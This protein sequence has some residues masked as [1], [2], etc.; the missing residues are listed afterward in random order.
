MMHSYIRLVRWLVPAIAL[1]A[2][3]ASP[4]I[5]A[6]PAVTA[7]ATI[8]QN[9]P[10]G[11]MTVFAAS[12]NGKLPP[13]SAFHITAAE[14][15]SSE[16]VAAQRDSQSGQLLFIS[17]M[18]DESL[19]G[20]TLE[21]QATPST[22]K[23]VVTIT[24][25]EAGWQFS[26]ADRPMLFF[27]TQVKAKDG[28]YARAAYVHP[29]LG[30]A[31]ETLTED[32]PADHLHHRGVYWAWHQ[33]WVGDRRGGDLWEAKQC[34]TVVKN[35]EIV[36]QGPIFATL[37]ATSQWESPLISDE[38]GKPIP[39][40]EE[41]VVIRVYHAFFD[42]QYIDFE[43][44]LKPLLPDIRIGGS[45]DVK[46]YSGFTVRVKPPA[47]MKITDANG[48]LS[49]DGLHRV[50]TWADVSGGFGKNSGATG[51]S[52]LAHPSLPEFPP[53]WLL[54]HYGM[55]NVLYPGR[56][57]VALSAD[58]PLTLKH[59]LVIHRGDAKQ[60]RVAEHQLLY[61]R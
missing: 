50:S 40:V 46:G 8:P 48:I 4:A 54:R 34:L 14:L 30:L 52:I 23:P 1:S 25:K 2:V 16:S 10:V 27:Q 19:R 20:K 44:Q 49:E 18:V 22:E 17:R 43:I 29:L 61:Q 41:T 6:E 31:G 60:S 9:F 7:S 47:D 3:I 13:A 21:L 12:P 32:F 26:D 28:K 59:R 11:L 57:A 53:K 51:I 36:D 15:A 24:K 5:A 38:T 33:L 56:E 39:M 55:Q 35:V 42:A 37:R 58:K 45:E